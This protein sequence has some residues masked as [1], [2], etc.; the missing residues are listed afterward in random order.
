MRPLRILILGNT[1][2]VG[3]EAQRSLAPLGE[4]IGLDYPEVDFTRPEQLSRK[5][6][7]LRPQV[8]YSPAAYTAVDK[9]ESEPERVRVINA[10][11]PGVLAEAAARLGAVLVH[12]STDYVFDGK[13]GC[14]YVE[15]DPPHP[16]SVYGQTKL[17]GEKAVQQVDCA[18]L[19]LRTAWVYSMRRESFVSKVMQWSK[20]RSSI[21]VVEDQV[22][23]PTW[24]RMLAE[25]S[26]QA[27]AMGREGLLDFIKE[28]RGVY[29]LAGDGIASRRE[30]AQ[31]IVRI[32]PPA[33][34]PLEVLPALS[35]EFPT[36]AERPLYSALDCSLFAQT[37][38]L[39]LP[40]WE[41]ALRLAME[42]F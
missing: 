26:A 29:H 42:S 37:F 21:R 10:A 28:R 27:L 7:E 11:A 4:V 36:P 32:R 13:K 33:D 20:D 14:A 38:G 18:H 1:G 6:L 25:T 31:A 5:V 41:Q 40:P 24:A 23:N 19:I 30:W 34:H 22:S 35:S 17:E 39:R 2:Q 12:F 8:I 9:A 16:L 3:W 15:S